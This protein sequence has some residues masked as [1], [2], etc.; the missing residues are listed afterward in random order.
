MKKFILLLV[1]ALLI[2]LSWAAQHDYIVADSPDQDDYSS[3]TY[4][5][6]GWTDLVVS[7]T[8]EITGIQVS[9]VWTTDTWSYEGSFIIESP[10]GTTAEIGVGQE[11]GE[12]DL[13]IDDFNGM[14][15]NGDW[16]LY[17]LD[18]YGD[19]GHQATN[20]TVS[21]LY[22]LAGAPG[23][24]SNPSPANNAFGVPVSGTLTWTFGAD[25]ETYQIWLGP[26][27]NM[28]M[29]DSGTAGATGSYAYEDLAGGTSYQWKVVSQNATRLSTESPIWNFV[30]DLSTISSFPYSQ[31]FDG[32]WGGTPAAPVGWQV[33]NANTDDYQWR[34]AST[35]ISPTHSAPF[36][37]HG[38]GNTDDW[39][40]TPLI[41]LNL[42][43]RMKWWDKVEG[44]S[45][46]N[47]Y[48]I[49]LSTTDTDPL[50]FTIEL[51]DIICTNTAW[52]EHSINLD[53]Y[54]GQSVY[55]AFYQ[56]ASAANYWGFGIDD[57]LL[58]EIP[59]T[60]I[61]SYSPSSINFGTVQYSIPTGPQYVTVTNIG[62]GTLTLTAADI[63]ISG[64]NAG[65]FHFSTD[66]LPVDIEA[67]NS[68]QIPVY[69]TGT[70]E[71]LISA[72]LTISYG[73]EDHDVALSADVT[74]D[75]TVAIG[76]GTENNGIP[77]YPYFGYTYSQSIYLQSEINTPDQRIEKISYYWN[78]VAASA[79]SNN[80]TI[81][82][83]HTA[84]TAFATTSDWVPLANLTQVFSGTVA[85]P[86]E[87]GWVEITL[88]NP[89]IYN[90]TGNLVI[91]VDENAT[92]Y[93][94]SAM[95]YYS[96]GATSY[97]S[98]R[99]I[100]DSTNADPSSPP[101][102]TPL[103]AYPNILMMFGDIPVGAPEAVTL[104]TPADNSENMPIEGFNL[105]WIPSS[106]GGVPT[107]YDVY[108][109]S[110]P[111][112]MFDDG[113]VFTGITGT[114][115]NPVLDGGITFEYNDLW[116]WTVVAINAEGD[117]LQETPFSFRIEQDPTV[118][119]TNDTPYV[120]GF[121]DATFPPLNW[122]NVAGSGS[123]SRST[124]ASGYG[125]GTAS[126]S[127]N[128][129]SISGS[130]P[131]SL[132]SPP[133][134]VSAVTQPILMFDHAYAT[135]SGE[136]DRMDVYYSIDG[137]ETYTLLLAMPGGTSGILNTGGTTTASFVPTGSQW[138]TQIL[139][140]P[141][142]T[143]MIKLTATS[144]YGNNLFV[145]NIRISD[146]PVFWDLTM[147][148]PAGS[149]TVTPT[150]GNHTYIQGTTVTLV[151][152][153]GLGWFDGWEVDGTAYS[154][155]IET[156]LTMDAD[157]EV[158]AFF[159]LPAG[160]LAEDFN[161]DDPVPGDWTETANSVSWETG[162]NT[163]FFNMFDN[164][165]MI[166]Q[167]ATDP[168]ERLITPAVILDGTINELSYWLAGGNN[169]YGYGSSTVQVKYKLAEASLWTNLGDPID[170]ANGEGPMYISL[171]LS[172][173]P[174]GTYQFA[175]A[176]TSTFDLSPYLSW[177]GIDNVVG[178]RLA[179]V[180]SNDLALTKVTYPN[181]IKTEGEIAVL[182]ATVKNTGINQQ[183]GTQVTFTVDDGRTV[184]TANIGTLGYNESEIVTVNYTAVEGRHT[185]SASIPADDDLDNNSASVQGVI[186]GTGNLAE[187]FEGAIEGWYGDSQWALNAIDWLPPYE[188]SLALYCYGG[189]FENSRLITPKV[190]VTGSEELNFY[191]SFGNQ[192]TGSATLAVEYSADGETWTN[193]L[194][195]FAPA[196]T[197]HLYT[198]DLSSIPAG[199]YYLSFVGSGTTDG[200]YN[201]ILSLDMII[202][203]ELLIKTP[204]NVVIAMSEGVTTLSWD[205]VPEA[206]SYKV[207]AGTD[208]YGEFDVLESTDTN[209]IV[210]NTP[211]AKLF[212]YVTAS[213]D[214]LRGQIAKS[215]ETVSPFS[216]NFV[217]PQRKTD[218]PSQNIKTRI[219]NRQRVILPKK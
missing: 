50:S 26:I 86:A 112:T 28:I 137:G 135:Y 154:T 195:A 204:E 219:V 191:A 82:M 91:A 37:A 100:S 60:P 211:D 98:L 194:P 101:A 150:P 126:A 186:A 1:L 2:G 192:T 56:Y 215:I 130:N 199:A 212:Y 123:W 11:S 166:G 153:P 39:L 158:Q 78:G 83:G 76:N 170:L 144:A 59:G 68:V 182:S 104:S 213:K 136:E 38:M 93:D 120:E 42:N 132:I 55:I 48:K 181:Q 138:N 102:G 66:N 205:A 21:F 52:T 134:D 157:H 3:N 35:Y 142:G 18:E 214:P 64:T 171:D 147:L 124:A 90:N 128:F 207:Y 122:Q 118:V 156:T 7:Q 188:G 106:T 115:F 210:L 22:V 29:V 148:D 183:S 61:F 5:D 103:M 141:S 81:Y 25:T 45:Y 165:T 202:G 20:V 62:G 108:M 8:D 44:A 34:Q 67:D 162:D 155:D 72:T 109:G 13:L 178:P 12:Y 74:P 77:V 209:S 145:D 151:A 99:H 84:V 189:T 160:A 185:I 33:I 24:A 36:A 146:A 30:T 46:P 51:A 163:F 107:S 121:E 89:F 9:Y 197:N 129:Y 177:V 16:K 125:E 131:F 140:L 152:K 43:A 119:V 70:T 216:P 173:I 168:E 116:Y 6:S 110:D 75:G 87:A 198:V 174:N 71:G 47:S 167:V 53:A 176:V 96:S 27:G 41:D 187:G 31:N 175:F 4:T 54:T 65:Q 164:F 161:L 73:G 69:V 184:L 80:W 95:F 105:S 17:I 200:T 217:V 114:S 58:E 208:P 94:T 179:S 169:V 218:T 206:Q 85:A 203:P 63:S 196:E 193:I 127:A 19:G 117:A 111:E 139:N 88:D 40:I 23:V 201:T 97:R 92:S 180:N 57:F 172:A 113:E 49:L 10:L 79:N 149:G 14:P 15:M 190:V 32:P 133:L 143:N 159:S